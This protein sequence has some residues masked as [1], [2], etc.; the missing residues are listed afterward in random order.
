[1]QDRLLQ[2]GIRD[3]SL[4]NAHSFVWMLVKNPE[5]NAKK[6]ETSFKEDKPLSPTTKEVATK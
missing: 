3:T 6:P 2:K 5:I 1:V 4:L